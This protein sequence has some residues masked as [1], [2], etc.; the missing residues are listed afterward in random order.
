[1]DCEKWEAE[2]TTLKETSGARG[3]LLNVQRGEI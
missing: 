2:S 3:F 1:M